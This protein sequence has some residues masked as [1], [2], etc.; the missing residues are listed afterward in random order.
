[1][2]NYLDKESMKEFLDEREMSHL[3]DDDTTQLIDNLQSNSIIKG[4]IYEP[5]FQKGTFNGVNS[6]AGYKVL[7]KI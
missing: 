7:F 3:Y 5:T 2:C 4:V 1:M 6:V